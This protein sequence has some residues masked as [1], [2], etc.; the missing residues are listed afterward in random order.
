MS[1]AALLLD[2]QWAG[3]AFLLQREQPVLD[4]H[5]WE[6]NMSCVC[7]CLLLSLCLGTRTSLIYHLLFLL[8]FGEGVFWQ[9]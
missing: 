4:L 9:F 8:G 3:V 2:W 1:S 6:L 5:H 7:M